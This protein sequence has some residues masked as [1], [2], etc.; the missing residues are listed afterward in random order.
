MKVR[1]LGTR[2]S[3]PISNQRSAHYGGS[4]PCVE[5]SAN[6]EMLI[7]D[8]GTGIVSS[9]YEKGQKTGVYHILLTH[10]TLSSVSVSQSLA[11]RPPNKD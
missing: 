1:L 7:L 9:Q 3:Y 8:A 10:P 6:G 5:I 11:S 2:G 4:T